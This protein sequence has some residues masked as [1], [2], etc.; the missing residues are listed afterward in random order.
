MPAQPD[1]ETVA[2]FDT[3]LEALARYLVLSE[4]QG[5]I[6]WTA[7]ADAQQLMINLSPLTGWPH[8]VVVSYLL[9]RIDAYC[10]TAAPQHTA[11]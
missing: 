5:R 2:A 11:N 1:P 7:L 3:A 4:L 10:A 6:D 8:E 9:A